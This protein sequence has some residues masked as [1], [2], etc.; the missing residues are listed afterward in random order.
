MAPDQQL[1]ESKLDS[2]ARCLLRI[3]SKFPIT[4]K[5]LQTDLDLQDIVVLNL[6]RAV[7]VSVDLAS[8]LL[9]EANLP[10]PSTMAESFTALAQIGKIT[11]ELAQRLVK[12]VGFRNLAVH[13]YEKLDWKIVSSIVNDRL[14]DFK[15]FAN[16]ILTK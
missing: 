8:I 5:R 10:V 6:E 11:P 12:S 4:P 13:E 7:Q 1:L 16:D 3:E 2:L 14:G 15:A 9:A